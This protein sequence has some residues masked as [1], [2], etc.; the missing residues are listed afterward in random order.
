MNKYLLL[1]LTFCSL[2]LNGQDCSLT[3]RGQVDDKDN[4]EHLPF[5]IVTL[6]PGDKQTQTDEHGRFRF[7]G[8][9]MGIFTLHIMHVGCR[10]T[11]LT[12]NLQN[13]IKINIQLPH[14]LNELHD[15]DVVAD[16]IE[17]TP[18]AVEQLTMKELDRVRGADLAAQLN[19]AAGVRILKSGPG[20]G[21]PVLNGMQGY[22]LLL[23]NHGVRQEGQ[24]WGAE[25]APEMDAF[26]T[27]KIT[28]IKGAAAVAYGSDAIAGVI[29]ADDDQLP[30]SSG[31]SA[32]TE[33][34]AESNGR[35]Y[36]AAARVQGSPLK[37]L[38][39][40]LQGSHRNSGD[41]S[42]PGYI[43]KNTG[44]REYNYSGR[45][46]Y[47]R[48]KSGIGVYF[49][50]FNAR[51][52][53]LE[54]AHADSLAQLLELIQRAEPEN[55]DRR[56]SRHIH[57]PYQNIHHNLIKVDADM[58]TGNRS[59]IALTY[60]Y[61]MNE[62]SE[63][64][65]HHHEQEHEHEQEDHDTDPVVLY[66]LGTQTAELRWEHDYIRSWK[67]KFG[68]QGMLQNNAVHGTAFIP[69]FTA[70]SYGMYGV[71][72]FVRP[73]Y[74]LEGGLRYDRRSLQVVNDT[75]L[76]NYKP[77]WFENVGYNLGAI[78]KINRAL[79]FSLNAGNG[80]R[81]PAANE[82]FGNGLHHGAAVIEKGQS[83]LK[84]EHCFSISSGVEYSA[85]TIN[86]AGSAY[87][88]QFDNFLGLQHT[89]FESSERGAFPVFTYTQGTAAIKGADLSTRI[90]LYRFLDFRATAAWVRGSL[91]GGIPVPYMP[92][93][94]YGSSL[95]WH[96]TKGGADF[97]VE[98]GIEYVAKQFRSSQLA[99]LAPPPAAYTLLNVEA[100]ATLH[101]RKQ[102]L[103]C[104]LGLYNL[105]NRRYRDY[106]DRFRYFAYAQGFNA[107]L[108]LRL[109][110]VLREGKS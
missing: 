47:H 44:L 33:T 31:V 4:G 95:F 86:L 9:C 66:R 45:L 69:A 60:A 77:L 109:P 35:K 51:V 106:L 94:K 67:G 82:L 30:D 28:V 80:W 81:A 8:L 79:R 53:I 40:R 71:E 38:S 23:L 42:A 57:A 61:Q 62:R 58:H 26:A 36:Y 21:K 24:Q 11:F 78:I 37:H 70:T 41:L 43:L 2:I 93:D 73:H 107:V 48:L 50:S 39:Y 25:H 102:P 19:R 20:P 110:L 88:Y 89:G 105:T 91:S 15:I 87:H 5:A 97:F 1:I 54:T 65:D 52:G 72:R 7:D 14:S 63:F 104:S 22:R 34:G 16:H 46:G 99:D 85:G 103:I 27:R 101:I 90:C 64:D 83:G 98:P 13:P 12:V 10:D 100:G 49:S 68:V 75:S 108:R 76:I 55:L 3:L 56:F 84:K 6:S 29:L 18:Y 74:E 92:A 32:E 96:F 59:R 17:T